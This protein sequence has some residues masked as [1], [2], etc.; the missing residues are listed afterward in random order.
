MRKE[1]E[2]ATRKRWVSMRIEEAGKL[3]D[4]ILQGG[5]KLSATTGDSGEPRKVPSTG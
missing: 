3:T 4:T 2:D 1:N 5:G